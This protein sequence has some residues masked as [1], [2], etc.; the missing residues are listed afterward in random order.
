MATT[1]T[2]GRVP[3][4]ALTSARPRPPAVRCRAIPPIVATPDDRRPDEATPVERCPQ[5]GG[6]R[7]RLR[8]NEDLASERQGCVPLRP[9]GRASTTMLRGHHGQI[10][11]AGCQHLGHGLVRSRSAAPTQRST[12]ATPIALLQRTGTGL[13]PRAL[14]RQSSGSSRRQP[15]RRRRSP[16]VGSG[17]ARPRDG[18][19]H[20]AADPADP[21][22]QKRSRHIRPAPARRR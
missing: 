8:L 22:S 14:S 1:S 17:E 13:T 21:G 4:H 15:I 2:A 20:G 19:A 6:P 3:A 7:H 5:L 9:P 18:A 16:A 10:F 12:A 11:Y